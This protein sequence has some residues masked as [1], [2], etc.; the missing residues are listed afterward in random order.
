MFVTQ[1]QFYVF[2]A[3]LA[4][5]GATGII[6]TLFS[7]FKFGIKNKYLKCLPDFFAFI[8]VSALYCVYS[9]TLKFPSVRA[10]MIIGVFIGITLY[11]KS[12]YIVLAKYIEMLYNII[13][14][15][16][17]KVKYDG[18]K[19]EKTNNRRDGGRSTSGGDSASSHA[20]SN[21]IYRRRKRQ[22]KGT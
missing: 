5:G 12:F 17:A 7:I 8:I 15:H 18:R 4:F 6:F 14:K 16:I 1:N 11:F 9:H 22:D 21:H 20:L 13:K 2:I 3:C 10:Y 19:S